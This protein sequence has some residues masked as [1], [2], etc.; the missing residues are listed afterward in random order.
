MLALLVRKQRLDAR[1][2]A[3]IGAALDAL[4]ISTVPPEGEG[5]RVSTTALA[6]R[7]A[8]TVYDASYLALALRSGGL[9]ATTDRALRAAAQ[10]YGIAFEA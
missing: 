5:W 6:A 1:R 2:S 10:E 9:L 8:L 7:H 3:R 4:R